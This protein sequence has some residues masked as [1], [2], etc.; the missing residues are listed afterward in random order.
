MVLRE[1]LLT[2]PS[3]HFLI[4]FNNENRSRLFAKNQFN[5]IFI[6]SVGNPS[7]WFHITEAYNGLLWV[8]C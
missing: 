6:V 2:F 5:L 8:S 1:V 7:L 4:F 3:I